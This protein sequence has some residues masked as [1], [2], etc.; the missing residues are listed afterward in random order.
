M[1]YTTDR[2]WSDQWIPLLRT[3]IGPYLLI[4]STIEQDR[5]EAADLVMFRARDMTIA[6]RVRRAGAAAKYPNQ[7]TIRC[8]RDNGSKTE[9][10]KI[11][12]GWGDWLFYGH[13]CGTHIYPWWIIDLS[14]FRAHLIR[15][16]E[17]FMHNMIP[18]GDGTHFA[19]FDISK[20][21]KDPP[22]LVASSEPDFPEEDLP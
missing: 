6:C 13:E 14:H 11:I 16:K 7:F 12:N 18:N 21:S 19:W 4:P 1:N 22:I 17:K 20:F 2:Q 9:L 8:K 5:Q 15:D 10:E 3:K